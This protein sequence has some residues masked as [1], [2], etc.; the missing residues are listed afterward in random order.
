VGAEVQ[1]ERKTGRRPSK[2]V[3]SSTQAEVD[4][5]VKTATATYLA[6]LYGE[7]AKHRSRY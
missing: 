5:N 2:L 3:L 4:T 1:G 6:D 7:A